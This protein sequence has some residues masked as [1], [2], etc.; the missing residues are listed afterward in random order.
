MVKARMAKLRARLVNVTAV[1]NKDSISEMIKEY[2]VQCDN[3]ISSGKREDLPKELITKLNEEPRERQSKAFEK[4]NSPPKTA[5]VTVPTPPTTT[6]TTASSTMATA[7]VKESKE[8]K[9]NEEIGSLCEGRI[10]LKE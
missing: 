7:G 5:A 1:G 6:A 3:A 10:W 8:V 4:A 2:L 9:Q